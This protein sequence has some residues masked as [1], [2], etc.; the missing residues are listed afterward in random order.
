MENGRS[1]CQALVIIRRIHEEGH[2][3]SPGRLQTPVP[4]GPVAAQPPFALELVNGAL[5]PIL[6]VKMNPRTFFFV[7]TPVGF[8]EAACQDR[9]RFRRY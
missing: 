4:I 1:F 6:V 3:V 7:Q 9:T 5:C 2:V 8:V